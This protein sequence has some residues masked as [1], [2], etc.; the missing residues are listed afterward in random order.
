[1]RIS[2]KLL[3]QTSVKRSS[4]ERHPIPRSHGRAMGCLPWTLRGK[5]TAIYRERT[6]YGAFT[7]C[8]K[9]WVPGHGYIRTSHKHCTMYLYS[10]ALECCLRQ[11][12]LIE[13]EWRMYAS[14]NLSSLVQIKACR[15]VGAKP[16]SEPMLHY[17]QFDLYEHFSMKY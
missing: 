8:M 12:K 3:W 13:A 7:V 6:V 1:M 11:S 15:L 9:T 14:V 5:N 10:H 16:L 17:H 4:H 2:R